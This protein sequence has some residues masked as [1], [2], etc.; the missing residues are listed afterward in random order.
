[1][2][3]KIERLTKEERELYE[4]LKHNYE[5]HYKINEKDDVSVMEYIEY[6]KSKII[7]KDFRIK[8]N[9]I[10]VKDV[11]NVKNELNNSKMILGL[12]L[13][14][15]SDKSIMLKDFENNKIIDMIV[16]INKYIRSESFLDEL[17]RI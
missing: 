17:Y 13:L 2:S 6:L 15:C 1:M 11:E 8:M 7:Y 9:L 10:D 5:I 16:K 14:E 4:K 3:K 12:C